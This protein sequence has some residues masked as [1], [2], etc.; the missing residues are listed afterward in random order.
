MITACGAGAGLAAAYN[1][2]IGGG[3]FALEVLLGTLELPFAI[4][5]IACSIIG[6]VASWLV[7]PRAPTYATAP[8]EL[9]LDQIGWAALVGPIAGLLAI[10]YIRLITWSRLDRPRKAGMTLCALLA[11]MIS[12]GA[13]SIVAPQLLGNGRDVV[14]RMISGEVAPFGFAAL[15]LLARPI[16]TALCL[17]AGVPGGLFTPTMTFGALLGDLLG[18]AWAAVVPWATP[19]NGGYAV[20]AAGA[21]LA[22]CTSAPV[23]A[24]VIMLELGHGIDRLIVPLGVAAVGAALTA[25]LAGLPSIYSATVQGRWGRADR[26]SAGVL[27]DD[28]AVVSAAEK[29]S[30]AI[31]VVIRVGGPVDVID[32]AGCVVGRLEPGKLERYVSG[33]ERLSLTTAGDVADPTPAGAR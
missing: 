13:A 27:P 3:L 28:T 11:V 14:Q 31:P 24:I 5:A 17:K 26:S 22:A 23:S 33:D 4:P 10:P 16:A 15:L 12:L 25:R 21:F 19:A 7:L 20:I 6:S 32:Q 18:R 29:L 2:P 30:A 9:H 1:L 8:Y